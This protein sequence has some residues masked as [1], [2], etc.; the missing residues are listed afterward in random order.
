MKREPKQK[1]T[2]PARP[3]ALEMSYYKFFTIGLYVLVS[4]PLFHKVYNASQLVIDE[5]F[6]LRQG[7]HYCNGSFEVVSYLTHN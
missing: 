2:G 7:A 5:E 1:L 3:G 6:H 4:V